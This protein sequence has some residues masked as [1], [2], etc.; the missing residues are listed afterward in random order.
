MG[1]A[2]LTSPASVYISNT[3]HTPGG[4]TAAPFGDYRILHPNLPYQPQWPN[5]SPFSNT[6]YAI[7]VLDNRR[8]RHPRLYPG[9]ERLRHIRACHCKH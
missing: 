1:P 8:K 5:P 4:L 2:A 7:R 3:G 9:Y 6:A